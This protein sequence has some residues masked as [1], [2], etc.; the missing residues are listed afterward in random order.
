MNRQ[1][2]GLTR[3]SE[4]E[5]APGR[6]WSQGRMPSTLVAPSMRPIPIGLL[7]RSLIWF[8]AKVSLP[9]WHARRQSAGHRLSL[10]TGCTDL[11]LRNPPA[12]RNHFRGARHVIPITRHRRERPAGHTPLPGICWRYANLRYLLPYAVLAD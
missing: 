9:A 8:P 3:T 2:L 7:T 5:D 4:H 11:S 6:R 10:A 1:L 12:D